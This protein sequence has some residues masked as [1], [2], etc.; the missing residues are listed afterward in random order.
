MT[1][2][3]LLW[4]IPTFCYLLFCFWYTDFSGPLTRAEI[5]KY[6]GMLEAEGGAPDRIND[7][8]A[9]LEADTGRQFIMVNLITMAQAP[10]PIAGAP[11]NASAQDLLDVYMAH[12]YPALFKRAC[13]P[14]FVGDA[15]HGALDSVGLERPELWGRTA[16]MRYRSRRDM[17]EIA[18]NP[19]FHGRHEFKIAAFDRTVAFPV[20]T[21]LYLSD[22]RVLLFVLLLAAVAV[23][24][25]VLQGRR[26]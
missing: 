10:P 11:E 16:L 20:E 1:K 15:V 4:S 25:I 21:V 6:V 5:D 14:V 8:R 3:M 9:F 18:T 17:I 22:P 24:D 13:H 2:R 23:G 19:A 12:M 7:I 26:R